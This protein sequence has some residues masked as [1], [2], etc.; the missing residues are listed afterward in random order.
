M[1]PLMQQKV[2]INFLLPKKFNR[3]YNKA[4]NKDQQTNTIDAVHIFYKITFRPVGVR[5]SEIEIFRYLF[6]DA[7]SLLIYN[8]SKIKWFLL[9]NVLT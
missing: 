4:K 9:M 2:F 6:P 8:N 5:F 3:K 1:L 7:H